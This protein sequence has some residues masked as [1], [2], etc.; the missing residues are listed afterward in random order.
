MTSA[1]LPRSR[2]E[3]PADPTDGVVTVV[4]VHSP[5]LRRARSRTGSR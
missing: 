3:S 2:S 5:E 4:D 1:A